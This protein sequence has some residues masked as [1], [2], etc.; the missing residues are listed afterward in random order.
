VRLSSGDEAV[1]GGEEISD[2][3][4]VGK[5]AHPMR[6]GPSTPQAERRARALS[7]TRC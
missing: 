7:Q 6:E 3:R 1:L 2:R 4:V 5:C